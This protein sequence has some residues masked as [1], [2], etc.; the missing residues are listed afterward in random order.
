LPLLEQPESNEMLTIFEPEKKVRLLERRLADAQKV[1]PFV[2][3]SE[4]AKA[5][6]Q[7]DQIKDGIGILRTCTETRRGH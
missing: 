1:L 6:A 7:L 4:F 2:P 3:A 5:K